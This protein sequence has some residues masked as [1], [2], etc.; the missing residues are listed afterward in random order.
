MTDFSA[1]F[2]GLRQ[3]A[4]T[5]P[6]PTEKIAAQLI[7]WPYR[8]QPA[9]TNARPAMINT[10]RVSLDTKIANRSLY[11]H[12]ETRALLSAHGAA[13]GATLLVTD[14]FCPN[15]AKQIALSGIARVIVDGEGFAKPYFIKNS[16]AFQTLSLAI[17]GWFGV[18]VFTWDQGK[19]IRLGPPPHVV[20]DIALTP[21]NVQLPITGALFRQDVHSRGLRFDGPVFTDKYD[22]RVESLTATLMLMTKRGLYP[23]HSRPVTMS[24]WPA[25]PRPFIDALVPGFHRYE[26]LS[27]DAPEWA[28]ELRHLGIEF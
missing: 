1:L 15:C 2:A 7:L 23:D 22:A 8:V 21:D 9:V 3:T 16:D 14:P 5:S 12:A 28:E 24:D 6:H 11:A 18:Q 26:I 27:N 17:L 10:R 20:S 19:L 4:Q 25:S 13:R